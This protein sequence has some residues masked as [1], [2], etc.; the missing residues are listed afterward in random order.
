MKVVEHLANRKGPLISFEIIPPQRGG[1]IKALLAVID[2][3]AKY[4]PPF[5]DITSHAAEVIY[6]ETPQ[7]IQRRIKRKRPG[8]L[9]ICALIQNKYNI[10]AVPHIICQ[11]FTREE[12][13]DFLIELHYLGI[14]NVLAIRGDENTYKKPLSFGRSVNNY[15]SELVTQIV[16][17]NH[18]KYLEEGLL[19]AKPTNFCV[20]VGGYPEKHFEAPNIKIDI[21]HTKG[22]VDA[23]AEYIVTQM[24]FDNSKYFEYIELCKEEGITVPIIPGLKIITSKTQLTNIPRN[25]YID[26][27]EEFSE[28]I[29]KAKP[30]HVLEIGVNWALKQVEEL[31]NKNVPAVHFYIM[32]NSKPI[33]MLMNKL[34]I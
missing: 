26:I 20:G 7:G 31:L 2:N 11:G 22:K 16:A 33:V 19:D 1:D 12:T 27:P 5:I 25:F 13:E 10:D 6:E 28:E 34:K 8:T 32:Q 4:H 30:E 17:M 24:F 18:G 9:G 3:I 15:A 23:G 14:D 21:K 29:L